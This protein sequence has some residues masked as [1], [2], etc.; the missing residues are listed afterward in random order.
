[1]Q[2]AE[3]LSKEE[4]RQVDAVVN[5]PEAKNQ[6]NG[7][8]YIGLQMMTGYQWWYNTYYNT[9]H[10]INFESY[11]VLNAGLYCAYVKPFEDDAPWYATPCD[12]KFCALCQKGL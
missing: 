2:I 1:M 11:I 9:T 6:C 4:Q 12:A 8:Y 10:Y 5:S 3:I 7:S